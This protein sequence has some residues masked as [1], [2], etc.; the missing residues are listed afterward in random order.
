M[1]ADLAVPGFG[2][3]FL[4]GL[5]DAR[6]DGSHLTDLLYLLSYKLGLRVRRT[7]QPCGFPGSPWACWW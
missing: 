7:M 4:A 3:P 2:D 6:P 5:A 1:R